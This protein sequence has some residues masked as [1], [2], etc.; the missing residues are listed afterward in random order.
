[1][2]FFVILFSAM[3]VLILLRLLWLVIVHISIR[4]FKP[5][6]DSLKERN[7]LFSTVSLAVYIITFLIVVDTLFIN[8]ECRSCQWA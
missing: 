1:M 5:S 7:V 4:I 6:D 8:I 3:I 2:N